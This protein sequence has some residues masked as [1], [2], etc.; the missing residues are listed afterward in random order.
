MASL[1]NRA[2]RKAKTR[3]LVQKTVAS[4]L[5]GTYKKVKK[6]PADLLKEIIE[7]NT[8]HFNAG[9]LERLLAA[10]TRVTTDRLQ[11]SHFLEIVENEMGWTNLLLRKQLFKAF[12]CDGHGDINFTEFC[13]GYS[14]M[15]RGTVPELLEF[16]WR[17]YHISGPPDAISLTDVYTIFRLGLAGLEEVR[18]MQGSA[19]GG[20]SEDTRFP[21]RTARQILESI[22]GQ[23]QAPLSKEEFFYILLRHRRLVDCLIPGFELIP[24]DPLHRAAEGGEVEEAVHL[25]KVDKFDVD[26]RD[27]KDFPTTP[28][29]L[30]AQFGHAEVMAVL[31]DHGANPRLLSK[32]GETAMGLAV[33]Y[34]FQRCVEFLAEAKL[35]VTLANSRGE[36]PFHTAA[37]YGQYKAMRSMMPYLLEPT[38][39]L[40]KDK[41][42]NTP[43]HFAASRDCWMIIDIFV[44]FDKLSPLDVDVRNAAGQTPLQLAADARAM[45]MA[46]KLIDM[47]ADP[48]SVD[49]SG[50]SI[51]NSAVRVPEN[52]AMLNLILAD[53]K[54][55]VNLPDEDGCTPLNALMQTEDVR[56][57]KAMLNAKADPNIPEHGTGFTPLHKA[58]L[59]K[60]LD[61]VDG[62]L[63]PEVET[64]MMRDAEGFTAL[65][66]ARTPDIFELLRDFVEK[67]YSDF[68]PDHPVNFVYGLI[69][70]EGRWELQTDGEL[71]GK[72]Q[73][74]RQK[75]SKSVAAKR[76]EHKMVDKESIK[77]RMRKAGLI[78]FEETV[79]IQSKHLGLIPGD[80][81]QFC[82]MRVGAPLYRLQQEAMK[83]RLQIRRHDIEKFEDFYID[84]GSYPSTGFKDLSLAER[85]TL[86][87]NIIQASPS[88]ESLLQSSSS[89]QESSREPLCAG[90]SISYY[91]KY[92]VVHDFV[93][94]H[95]VQARSYLQ[96]YW[97][98]RALATRSYWQQELLNYFSNS[99]HNMFKGL[100]VAR[101]YFGLKNGFYFG[102]LSYYTNWL[103][104]PSI[105]GIVAFG[106]EFIPSKYDSMIE[107]DPEEAER[108]NDRYDHP[109][110]FVYGSM[111]C[112]WAATVVQGWAA[113][114]TELAHRWQ[115]EN[116]SETKT[117]QPNPYSTA[118]VRLQFM[119]GSWVYRAVMTNEQKREQDKFIATVTVPV[120]LL[121]MG[122]VVGWNFFNGVMLDLIEDDCNLHDHCDDPLLKDRNIYGTLALYSNAGMFALIITFLNSAFSAV[123]IWLTN[124]ENHPSM[125][126]FENS[127]AGR[128]FAFMC[129]NNY[130]VLFYLVYYRQNIDQA[131]AMLAAIMVVSQFVGQIQEYMVP[132]LAGRKPVEKKLAKLARDEAKRKAKAEKEKRKQKSEEREKMLSTLE[133]E[134]ST[135]KDPLGGGLASIAKAMAAK[136][137]IDED[138]STFGKKKGVV[139]DGDVRDEVLETFS[140]ARDEVTGDDPMMALEFAEIFM[141]Y[142]FI[143]LFGAAWPL[144]ALAAF[145]NNFCEIRLDMWKFCNFVRRPFAEKAGSIG[146]FWSL[147][148]EALTVLGIAN[149]C[150]MCALASNTMNEY[151]FPGISRTERAFAAF[152]AQDFFLLIYFFIRVYYLNRDAPWVQQKKKEPLR[153]IRDAYRAANA[154]RERR[155]RM[156][157]VDPTTSMERVCLAE[158]IDDNA[159]DRYLKIGRY[160]DSLDPERRKALLV[161]SSSTIAS[162]VN[163]IVLQSRGGAWADPDERPT[164]QGLLRVLVPTTNLADCYALGKRLREEVFALWEKHQNVTIMGSRAATIMWLRQFGCIE[165]GCTMPQAER[166]CR[167]VRHVDRLGG[168]AWEKLGELSAAHPRGLMSVLARVTEQEGEDDGEP[169][170]SELGNLIEPVSLAR[171]AFE[172]ADVIRR[173]MYE[174][175]TAQKSLLHAELVQAVCEESG[176]FATQIERYLL[177]KRYCDGLTDQ[178]R[179]Q[180]LV[181]QRS[182]TLQLC[183][184]IRS[185]EEEGRWRDPGE[186]SFLVYVPP[187]VITQTSIA[188]QA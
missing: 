79:L 141:Q 35:D 14:T 167:L 57:L 146:L 60:W 25:I 67:V 63:G 44:E 17:L 150:F 46:R 121:F 55:D 187:V 36:T 109:M 108:L 28:M 65:D 77:K 54:V 64:K 185:A 95:D 85:Q 40:L 182:P 171:T 83:M 76:I 135:S 86:V 98:V 66:Y 140:I 160:I 19:A 125:V 9:E 147:V 56:M 126:A 175:W 37:Y 176:A 6:S 133:N 161:N 34:G 166:Y 31:L 87:L 179:N 156:L 42:G 173:K 69:F 5:L 111:L 70:D 80:V 53:P 20:P 18:R 89:V 11:A 143:V 168:N 58:T 106:I 169:I 7:N 1:W 112:V 151:F 48:A 129:V 23:R 177:V 139:Q 127:L 21:D 101:D 149:H 24:Q 49:Y 148:F 170:P 123:S 131:A 74:K 184:S 41:V 138:G 82:L 136:E 107:D 3:E 124:H 162:L 178:Q 27:G 96:K 105:A 33:R 180:V 92:K 16:A 130:G 13:E 97:D 15:L 45:R 134:S 165:V 144:A 47:G 114:Q 159:A 113:K 61:G 153:F 188:E 186:P 81:Q 71:L 59:R 183:A 75:V 158:E 154:L 2:G 88:N 22:V 145:I 116:F 172:K 38:V 118:P 103:F 104:A 132:W 50:R 73:L 52:E 119:N 164:A 84:E 163:T 93:V 128:V 157:L 122:L 29:H 94:L 115:V 100:Q 99:K 110:M 8:T 78:V 4:T 90:I 120:T 155:Y 142:G 91:K 10:Y 51:L 62:L 43:L 72:R 181:V 26:G 32:E 102:F 137:G 30:A 39:V 12:D 68:T 117:P 152:C 174:R